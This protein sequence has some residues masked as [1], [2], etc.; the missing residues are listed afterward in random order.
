MT[1]DEDYFP[2]TGF[3]QKYKKGEDDWTQSGKYYQKYLTD[4]LILYYDR[5]SYKL[6][7]N[8][9]GTIN[10]NDVRFE[11]DI[12]GYGAAPARPAGYENAQFIGWF[13]VEPS[14]VKYTPGN[15]DNTE[16]F[17][18]TNKTMPAKN[19]VLYAYWW[20]PTI[21]VDITIEVA[22][23]DKIYTSEN[24]K[25]GTTIAQTVAYTNAQTYISDHNLS[26]VK[27]VDGDGVTVDINEP[28]YTNKS[29]R[30]VFSG[31]TYTL[32]YD[33]TEGASGVAPA[34]GHKY[35]PDSLA[36]VADSTATK[37]GGKLVFGYWTDSKGNVY[38]PGQY[39][40]M[41]ADTT[42]TANYVPAQDKIALT[43]DAN[44]PAGMG[45]G[46]AHTITQ[47]LVNG[48]VTVL[49]F[50]DAELAALTA[51][52]N[53]RFVY[54]NTQPDGSGTS[55]Y[56]DAQARV[57]DKNGENVLY[58]IWELDMA[59]YTIHHYLEGTQTKIADDETGSM[60][61]GHKL[62]ATAK[63]KTVVTTR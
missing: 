55:F 52:A 57:D 40:A 5:V 21:K 22:T 23:G 38:Y 25:A 63:P 13:E 15:P 41:N 17:D 44:W 26:L 37:E 60:T 61:I 62:T 51:P 29:I 54:W 8:N 50:A 16:P 45:D 28:L 31:T 48:V 10:S 4:G 9:Y 27:W 53:Y 42:L 39:I 35:G 7:L 43:Y 11:A 6:E 14:A 34:D 33:L 56:A 24:L 19:L 32:T 58:A 46:G 59:K 1:Y 18:F 47:L 12:S 36:R 2:I 3:V 30:P 49:D 20:N